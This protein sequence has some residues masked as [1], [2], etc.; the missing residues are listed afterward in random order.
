MIT[1][2]AILS[3]VQQHGIPLVAL[4]V[5]L[6][7]LGVPT[8]LPVEIAL[9]V[10]GGSSIHSFPAL[11]SGLL[12]VVAADLIGTTLLYTVVRSG[13]VRLLTRLA[14]RLVDASDGGIVNRWRRRLGN[15]DVAVVFV[16]RILPL[17]RMWATISAGLLRVR[18]RDF[19]SGAA[20]AAVVWAGTPL[21]IGYLF[22]D[23]VTNLAAR[24]T[25]A[26]HLLTLIVPVMVIV[27]VVGW[28]V[29]RGHFLRARIRRGRSALGIGAA[30]V[31][32]VFLVRTV[33][34]NDDAMNQ[35]NVSISYPLLLIW[36]VI[37][38]A[39]SA[40]LLVVAFADLRTARRSEPHVPVS[41][42]LLREIGATLVWAVLVALGAGIISV[43]ELRYPII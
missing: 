35:G 4:L 43:F 8:I 25:S 28:W 16:T 23:Q 33:L 36:L 1:E 21:V 13:G 19:L 11:L 38:I 20:P 22:R 37:L 6:G 34:A 14:P 12:L 18:R 26:S 5:L 3:L 29:W 15:R 40:A 39:L 7:E 41:R 42:L 24:F 9:L 31:C 32:L 17:V 10:V 27:A 2:Q 30:V